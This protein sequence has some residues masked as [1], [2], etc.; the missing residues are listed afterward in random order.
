MR[1]ATRD[2]RCVTTARTRARSVRDA[3][4]RAR[5]AG[6]RCRARRNDAEEAFRGALDSFA[7]A[8]LRAIGGVASEVLGGAKGAPIRFPSGPREDVALE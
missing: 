4:A 2:A 7:A 3:S 5:G 8:T 6:T 1:A